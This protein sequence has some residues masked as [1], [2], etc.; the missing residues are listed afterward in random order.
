MHQALQYSVYHSVIF[1]TL[2][3]TA[4]YKVKTAFTFHT[5]LTNHILMPKLPFVACRHTHIQ[6]PHPQ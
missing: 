3:I 4:K 6:Q 2:I 1:K 5:T